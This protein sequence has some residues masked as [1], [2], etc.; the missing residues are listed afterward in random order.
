MKSFILLLSCCISLN[1][2][3][4]KITMQDLIAMEE[5]NTPACSPDGKLVAFTRSIKSD[6]QNKANADI[7]VCSTDGK[8][9]SPINTSEKRDANPHWSP[10]QDKI[11]FLS[12]RGTHAQVYY[13]NLSG[14]EAVQFT[15]SQND[16]LYFTWLGDT[17][18]VYLADEPR[19]SSVVKR[20]KRTGGAVHSWN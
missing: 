6:W 16:V 9:Q 12:D 5:I 7:W 17:S 8:N 19:D 13:I 4:Q 15:N 2:S 10:S 11:G 1:L 20:E 18:V 14:G 3:A